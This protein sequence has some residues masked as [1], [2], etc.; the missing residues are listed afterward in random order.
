[1][2]D[3]DDDNALISKAITSHTTPASGIT[4]LSL[5]ADDTDL[6]PWDYVRE[7]QVKFSNGQIN[8][9]ATWEFI[10]EQDVTKRTT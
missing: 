10:V 5:T 9:T 2:G 1:M 4:T 3:D 8:S 6:S 7:I